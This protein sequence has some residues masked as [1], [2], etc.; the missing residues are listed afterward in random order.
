MPEMISRE[1]FKTAMATLAKRFDVIE[2]DLYNHGRDGLKT[3]F[4]KFITEYRTREDEKMLAFER[5]EQEQLARDAD[6]ER[7]EKKFNR[8]AVRI[9]L[10][11]TILG[12]ILGAVLFYQSYRDKKHLSEI[13][14]SST[15]VNAD[16]HPTAP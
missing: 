12:A 1:E 7:R 8:F 10:V 13:P 15:T 16:I 14:K 4:L 3:Q 6:Q 2:G 9:T 11:C 5:R